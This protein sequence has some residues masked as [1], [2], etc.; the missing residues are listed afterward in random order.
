MGFR[1]KRSEGW[2]KQDAWIGE[3]KGHTAH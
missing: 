1:K 3:S 2:R